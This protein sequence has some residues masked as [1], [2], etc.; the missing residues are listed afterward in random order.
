[1]DEMES[2]F[3]KGQGNSG[4]SRYDAL[5]AFTEFF[6]SGNG[7]GKKSTASQK[8]ARANFGRGADWKNEAFRVLTDAEEFKKSSERGEMLLHDRDLLK[9]ASN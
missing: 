2:L 6:T 9:A 4:E 3:V 5:N 7:V 1:M 8:V